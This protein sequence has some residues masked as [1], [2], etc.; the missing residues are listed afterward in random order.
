MG[1]LVASSFVIAACA[2]DEEELATTV[3]SSPTEGSASDTGDGE[4]SDPTSAGPDDSTGSDPTGDS[5]DTDG[6]PQGDSWWFEI[7]VLDFDRGEGTVLVMTGNQIQASSTGDNGQFALATVE[8]P[9][10]RDVGSHEAFSILG[11]HDEMD[12]QRR[13]VGVDGDPTITIG[14][15]SGEPFEATCS[16]TVECWEG[17]ELYP[18]DANGDTLPSTIGNVSGYIYN[19]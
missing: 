8:Q 12:P 1:C 18:E 17:D 2:D 7:D 11:F 15:S 10:S 6:E 16:G 5:D 13:C 14:V 19:Q 4:T 3:G 9:F